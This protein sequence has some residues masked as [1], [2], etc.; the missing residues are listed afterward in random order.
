[1]TAKQLSASDIPSDQQAWIVGNFV[2]E[3]GKLCEA[4]ADEAQLRENTRKR[5]AWLREHATLEKLCIP[6]DTR[7]DVRKIMRI[8]AAVMEG[9]LRNRVEMGIELQK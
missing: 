8:L 6:E 1:M 5:I 9:W 7:E 4:A 3:T 2:M